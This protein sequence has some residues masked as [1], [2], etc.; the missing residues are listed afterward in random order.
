MFGEKT[1]VL[2]PFGNLF[3]NLIFTL[4]VP[5]AF[6]SI[7]S[8]IASMDNS[9]KLGKILGTTV[10]IFSI[11]ATMIGQFSWKYSLYNAYF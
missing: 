4:L 6:F 11:I 2:A 9:K 7:S 3:L 1:E 5:I 8:A 10:I